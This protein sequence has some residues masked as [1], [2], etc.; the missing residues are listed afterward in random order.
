ML[1]IPCLHKQIVYK[2]LGRP[3]PPALNTKWGE[4]HTNT[5]QKMISV[6]W[7][8]SV[9]VEDITIQV[10]HKTFLGSPGEKLHKEVVYESLG[11]PPLPAY[12]TYMGGRT[13]KYC[14]KHALYDLDGHC[15]WLACQKKIGF[16]NI[17]FGAAHG[18]KLHK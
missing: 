13:H 7:M 17:H 4:K 18:E 6:A 3:P 11:R 15:E 5:A 1:Y 12:N 2:S 8:V 16:I 10:W 14:L 9:S